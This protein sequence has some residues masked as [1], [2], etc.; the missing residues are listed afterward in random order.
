MTSE[1]TSE[2][3]LWLLIAVL[4]VISAGAYVGNEA[5]RY[6]WDLTEY[7]EALDS[8]FPYRYDEPYPFLYPPVAKQLFTMARSHLF[9][10]LSIGYVGA[11]ALFVSTIARLNMPRRFE[12]VAAATTIGG[13]GVV[14]LLSGNVAILL[15]LT[16]LAVALQASMGSTIALTMLPVVVA[17]GAL[18]K[19]QF[20]VYAGLLL[21][22][23]RSW[24]TAIVKMAAIALFTG[25][26]HLAYTGLQPVDWLEY[27]EAAFRRTVVEKDFAWGPAGFTKRFSDA[28]SV[29]VVA[30]VSG[31][32][33][34][35]A[36]AFAAWRRSVRSGHVPPKPVAVSLLFVAL[37][38]ANPRMPP[39]DVFVAL[40]AVAVA[41]AS[42]A[43]T[44]LPR[45]LAALLSV[46]LVPWLI[47]EFARTPSAW[48]S[49]MQSTQ[50]GHLLAI[51]VLLIALSRSS[52]VTHRHAARIC[53]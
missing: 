32:F 40:L 20:I 12:W 28:T 43:S 9:E 13:L 52:F 1:T 18:I 23:E 51:L 30:S 5:A 17:I 3:A 6:F 49:W 38:F 21:L 35:S 8:P 36:L 45:L 16:V 2:R 37:S 41:C 7:V 15:N 31:F 46:N 11:A 39:Y 53:Q 26:V 48:P 33:I 4:S 25:A 22:L 14:S 44:V 27:R 29:A 10:L 47:E 19:P 24:R 34:V 42:S 50:I